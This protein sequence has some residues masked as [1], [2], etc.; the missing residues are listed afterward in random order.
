MLACVCSCVCV[1]SIVCK[2]VSG[3]SFQSSLRTQQLEKLCKAV[4]KK[5]QKYC[6]THADDDEEEE[7]GVAAAASMLLMTRIT[8]WRIPKDPCKINSMTCVIYS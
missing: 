8:T 4:K 5:N 6:F 3:A 7:D 1:C 2:C